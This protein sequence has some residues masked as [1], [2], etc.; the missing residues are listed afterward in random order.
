MWSHF[1]LNSYCINYIFVFIHNFSQPNYNVNSSKVMF[2]GYESLLCIYA[3]CVWL[4]DCLHTGWWP[5]T[6]QVKLLKNL[7]HY[8]KLV[9][10]FEHSS[11]RHMFVVCPHFMQTTK[12]FWYRLYYSETLKVVPNFLHPNINTYSPV[13]RE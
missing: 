5:S 12:S 1:K 13:F 4:L 7:G 11:G 9:H 2:A 3:R 6:F 10:A 8:A